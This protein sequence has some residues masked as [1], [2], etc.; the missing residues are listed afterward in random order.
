MKTKLSFICVCCS[1][2]LFQ[3]ASKKQSWKPRLNLAM[4]LNK[5]D[6]VL[7]GILDEISW[8]VK[9]PNKII[10]YFVRTLVTFISIL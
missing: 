6:I 7:E 8:T 10:H 2:A 3:D 1:P 4:E 5:T 9:A